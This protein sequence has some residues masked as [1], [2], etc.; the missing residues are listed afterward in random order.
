MGQMRLLVL[1]FLKWEHLE[2]L[3]WVFT[4]FGESHMMEIFF[5]KMP[6]SNV[7]LPIPSGFKLYTARELY[8]CTIKPNDHLC[9]NVF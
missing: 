3:R 9:T 2:G 8:N 4:G 7:K 1:W 6:S 5:L